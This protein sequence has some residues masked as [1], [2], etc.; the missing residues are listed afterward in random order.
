MPLLSAEPVVYPESLLDESVA[1]ADLQ[2]WWALHTR[3]RAEKALARDLYQRQQAF[4]L[5]LAK[6]QWRSGGRLLT[7]HVPLF[8]GY[9]F[10]RG[11]ETS[12]LLALQTNHVARALP[13]PDGDQLRADLA[14]VHDLIRKG[15]PLAPEERLQP[16]CPVTIT[17]GPL[18]GLEGKILRRDKR[19]RFVVEVHFIQR[20]ASVEVEGWMLEPRGTPQAVAGR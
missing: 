6:K 4:F 2:R 12:R 16:G 20:G 10:L 5:P 15:L 11:D 3:P 7:S 9:L 14:R 19:L 13:V 18:A 1:P 17:S 8:P